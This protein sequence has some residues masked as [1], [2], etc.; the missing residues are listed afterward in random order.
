MKMLVDAHLPK[1][2]AR[3]LQQLGHDAI[4]TLVLPGRNSTSDQT[5]SQI[6]VDEKRII[7][8]KDSDFVDSFLLLRKPPYLLLVSTGNIGNRELEQLF[9]DSV[10]HLADAFEN[11]D[12]VELTRQHVTCHI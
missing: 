11:Y 10:A 1:R 12:Y 4:H 8:T 3:L 2:L 9:I 7:V 5:I 6:A